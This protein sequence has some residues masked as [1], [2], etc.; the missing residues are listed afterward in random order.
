MLF[1]AKWL[2]LGVS[3]NLDSGWWRF[4]KP[5]FRLPAR[6]GW[7]RLSHAQPT[8]PFDRENRGLSPSQSRSHSAPQ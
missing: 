7:R 4:E 3:R 1:A 2:E 5:G 8:R 6:V